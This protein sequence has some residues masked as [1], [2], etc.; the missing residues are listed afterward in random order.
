MKEANLYRLIRTRL[1]QQKEIIPFNLKAYHCWWV[2]ISTSTRVIAKKKKKSNVHRHLQTT[3]ISP[4][5][6]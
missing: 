1:R 6:K 2:S 5:L 3:F 4:V